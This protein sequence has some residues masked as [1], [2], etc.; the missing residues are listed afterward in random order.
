MKLIQSLVAIVGI[1]GEL[2]E[3]LWRMK[4]LWLAPLMLV[5]I[6]FG[7]LLLLAT[8]SGIAPFIYTLF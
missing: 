6:V 4:R 8:T 2:F 5:L 3:G 1:V 7:L